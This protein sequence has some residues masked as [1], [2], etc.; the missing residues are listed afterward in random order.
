M[1]HIKAF[2]PLLLF[3][4]VL[5][6]SQS[7]YERIRKE[8]IFH[9]GDIAIET[10]PLPFSHTSYYTAE[11]G[12]PL[13]R[14]FLSFKNRVEASEFYKTKIV[15]NSIEDWNKADQ[16][17]QINID[18]GALTPHNV[19]LLST[20]NFAHRIPLNE[21]IYAEVSLLYREKAFQG[22]EWSYPDYLLDDALAFFS[23]ARLDLLASES[24]PSLSQA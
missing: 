4:S 8:L 9:F 11:M 19:L 5:Y 22:L 20:K 13:Y 2:S 1:G 24:T 3:L 16:K 15:S 21:G 18:P 17:R 10:E 14:R 12:S 23:R 6:S 7:V